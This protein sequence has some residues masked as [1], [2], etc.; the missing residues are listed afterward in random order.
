MRLQQAP[1]VCR[2]RVCIEPHE[3]YRPI[4]PELLVQ[5]EGGVAVLIFNRPAM[6]Y[7][8]DLPMSQALQLETD[9]AGLRRRSLRRARWGISLHRSVCETMQRMPH[10]RLTHEARPT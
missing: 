6:L 9:F 4:T 3:R 5:Q 10:Q 2:A 8:I 7:A 1:W